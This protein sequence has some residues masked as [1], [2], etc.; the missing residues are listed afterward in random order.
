MGMQLM[1]DIPGGTL[2]VRNHCFCLG[3]KNRKSRIIHP[4][5]VSAIMVQQYGML[6]T[7]AVGL[8]A[9]FQIPVCLM[10]P[11]YPAVNLQS[12]TL[13][14]FAVIRRRQ[15]IGT[16]LQQPSAMACHWLLKKIDRQTENIQWLW[17]NGKLNKERLKG[18]L[19]QF[20][21]LRGNLPI[22]QAGYERLVEFTGAEAFW[23]SQYWKTIALA[24]DNPEW[25]SGRQQ[26]NCTDKLNPALNYAYAILLHTI[27]SQVLAHGLDPA[28]GIVHA[29]GYNS[30]PLVY[31][32]MEPWRPLVDRWLLEWIFFNTPGADCWRK[33]EQ[34]IRLDK[35]GRKAVARIFFENAAPKRGRGHAAL[36]QQVAAVCN[37]LK[38]HFSTMPYEELIYKLNNI[39]NGKKPAEDS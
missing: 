14:G 27:E 30:Q 20:E 9:R 13:S 18:I 11:A 19:N 10:H 24:F 21:I 23:A 8:A 38:T 12:G 32:L 36:T 29:D 33:T 31:D 4:A 26:Q 39:D 28:F 37:E 6:S 22:E 2:T 16:L 35:P 5:R 17:E 3:G 1:V 7:A 25:F 34:G 15:A